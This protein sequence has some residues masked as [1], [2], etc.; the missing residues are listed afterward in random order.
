[1]PSNHRTLICLAAKRSGTTA[2]HHIFA[3]HP[4]VKIVHPDQAVKNNEP[5]FW[6]FAASA[7]QKPD[8]HVGDNQTAYQRFVEQMAVIAPT[9][10]VPKTLTAAGVFDLWDTIVG[11]YGGLVFDKSPRYLEFDET[12]TLLKRYKDSGRDVRFFGI[13]RAPWDTIS[14]QFELWENVFLPGT[15]EFRDQKW[16]EY[17][18]RFEQLQAY[19][20]KAT[21]PLYYYERVANHPQVYIPQLLEHCGIDDVPESYSHFRPVSV[22]RYYRTQHPKLRA[23]Q[24]SEDL[25]D[26]AKQHDYEL[27][28][29]QVQQQ[30]RWQYRMKDW[31]KLAQRIYYKLRSLVPSY[32]NEN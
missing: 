1:M 24:P 6:N 17:Y 10:T 12:L 9:I 23:W 20:D 31:R 3:K 13:M 14:S 32:S 16:L 11:H 7:L 8:E 19:Y 22:G 30:I 4:Q 25:L 2:I 5:N 26:F 15:P 18:R 29:P 28:S 21:V 27:L